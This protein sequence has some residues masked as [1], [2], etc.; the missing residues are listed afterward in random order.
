MTYE[1]ST[2]EAL[3]DKSLEEILRSVLMDRKVLAVQL[4]DGA[5]V[6]IQPRPHLKPLPILNGYIPKEWKEAIYDEPL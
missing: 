2:I 6:V 1:T 5:E 3:E 4:P